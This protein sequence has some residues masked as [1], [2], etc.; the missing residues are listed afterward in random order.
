VS[1]RVI[2]DHATG[3]SKG[4]AYVEFAS[5][6]S[7]EAALAMDGTELDGRPI[8]VDR[9]QGR[10]PKAAMEKRQQRFG[11]AAPSEPSSTL[12]VGN[13][14][15]GVTEDALWEVF[16]EYGD[17]KNVRLP[18]DY[19]SQRPKGFGYVEFTDIEAAKKAFEGQQGQELDGRAV[20]ID[21][22]QPRDDSGGG[23][24]GFRGGRG[25]DRGGFRGRGGD[26][27]GFRGGDRGGFR[28]GRGGG[29]DRGGFRGGRGGGDRGYVRSSTSSPNTLPLTCIPG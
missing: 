12:F 24:G 18:K 21:Y 14:S 16:G 1:A 20:R 8:R 19:E 2:M 27:G 25:G 5:A 11:D 28:G 9:S 10:N 17:V 7:V 29:G 23:R 6:D 4:F 26:R 22:S 15:F 3:R 13:L